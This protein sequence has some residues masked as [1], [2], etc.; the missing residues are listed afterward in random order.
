MQTVCSWLSE[1]ISLCFCFFFCIL[2]IIF[3]C[4]DA[5]GLYLCRLWGPVFKQMHCWGSSH[6]LMS[7]CNHFITNTTCNSWLHSSFHLLHRP[8]SPPRLVFFI[9]QI[10]SLSFR[11]LH[12]C[13]VCFKFPM[14]HPLIGWFLP[15]RKVTIGRLLKKIFFLVMRSCR[16][17]F[18]HWLPL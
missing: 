5:Y 2:L 9:F 3:C 15:A 7:S 4:I 12:F 10:H 8:F 13:S 18:L 1:D 17:F 6:D 14:L 16:F 11:S